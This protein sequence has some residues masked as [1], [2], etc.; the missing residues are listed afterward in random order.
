[1]RACLISSMSSHCSLDICQYVSRATS[2]NH[3]GRTHSTVVILQSSQ[4]SS[5][6]S[7]HSII[8]VSDAVP[9]NS[10]ISRMLNYLDAMV[11][12][13][14]NSLKPFNCSPPRSCVSLFLFLTLTLTCSV[15]TLVCTILLWSNKMPLPTML[16]LY[17]FWLTEICICCKPHP[18]RDEMRRVTYKLHSQQRSHFCFSIFLVLIPTKFELWDWPFC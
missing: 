8:G 2:F 4:V 7:N 17:R 14:W 9:L 1:M 11:N 3:S 18:T 6:S 12:K 15:N 16:L 10:G 13:S 5:W